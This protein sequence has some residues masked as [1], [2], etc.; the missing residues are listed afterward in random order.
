[1]QQPAS[2]GMGKGGIGGLPDIRASLDAYKGYE[3]S[4]E[5]K[6]FWAAHPG[7]A[8]TTYAPGYQ[9]N[10]ENNFN[11]QQQPQYQLGVPNP[12]QF[13]QQPGSTAGA[14]FGGFTPMP[15]VPDGVMRSNSQPPPGFIPQA[16]IGDF[17][18]RFAQAARD[19]AG[20]DPFKQ[21]DTKLCAQQ[22]QQGQQQPFQT[23]GQQI[24]SRDRA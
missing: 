10:W 3:P 5:T 1:M 2:P 18:G 22:G 8:S 6:A 20:R 7:Y 15:M 13:N 17:D 21:W 19:S 12:E 23:T 16:S 11:A 14:P 9:Q 24:R 4:A